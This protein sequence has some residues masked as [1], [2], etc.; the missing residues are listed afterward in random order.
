M[1]FLPETNTGTNVVRRYEAG[2]ITVNDS[3]YRASIII[4]ETDII[5]DWQPPAFD[6]VGSEHLKPFLSL[7]MDVLLLGCGETQK[8]LHPELLQPFMEKNVGV[9][10]MNTAAACR[11]F[12]V[13][14]GEGRQV[15]AGLF[16]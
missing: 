5:T 7:Q 15:V 1:Q 4:T 9:E 2:A 3:T 11:T 8:F 14:A 12:N 10:I 13:L 6:D 16:L